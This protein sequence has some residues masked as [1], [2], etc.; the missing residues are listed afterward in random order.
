M[1]PKPTESGRLLL[2]G[3]YSLS[4]KRR[5]FLTRF[6][7]GG[8]RRAAFW[9]GNLVG[10]VCI[11]DCGKQVARTT[12]SELQAAAWP[13]RKCRTERASSA[14]QLVRAHC[15]PDS[16]RRSPSAALPAGVAHTSDARHSK[17]DDRGGFGV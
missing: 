4:I 12:G 11:L 5:K 17:Q 6:S 8:S 14:R 13:K 1:P 9:D 15:S 16:A 7:V 10:W 3:Q 2:Q